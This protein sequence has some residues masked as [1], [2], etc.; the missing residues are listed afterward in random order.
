MPQKTALIIVNTI[1][2][3]AIDRAVLD[4]SLAIRG[5]GY[6]PIVVSGGGRMTHEL[7]REN[8]EHVQMNISSS[9][10]FT[11]GRNVKNLVEFARERGVSII[12]AFSPDAAYHAAKVSKALGIPFVASYMKIYRKH[13]LSLKPNRAAYMAAADFIIAPSEFMA[14]YLQGAHHIPHNKIAIIPQWVDTDILN[15]KAVSAERIIRTA[16]ELRVPE[17]KFIIA[18]ISRLSRPK[19]Q[20]VLLSALSRLPEAKRARAVCII[21]SR[22]KAKPSVEA[23]LKKEARRLGVI[24]IVHIADEMDDVPA[25]LM[26]SDM[27]VSTDLKPSAFRYHLLSAISL[28][29]P[30]IASNIGPAHE[31]AFDAAAVRLYEPGDAVAL[32]REMGAVM[33]LSVE[34]RE[35]LGRKSQSFARIN[36]SRDI[37]APKVADIYDFVLGRKQ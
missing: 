37:M 16:R 2:E 11:L 5:R 21:M 7:K 10:F 26:L 35:A 32:A 22:H 27:F 25:M 1:D 8:I 6:T 33:E 20:K 12:H 9:D 4:V 18:A 23:A 31:Y 17:D 29:R 19:G 36:C 13:L 3:G 30:V 24:D 14:S 28:G 34:E 15:T